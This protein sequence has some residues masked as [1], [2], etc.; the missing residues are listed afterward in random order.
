MPKRV[1]SITIKRRYHPCARFGLFLISN[2][3]LFLSNYVN[4]GWKI[5]DK[6]AKISKD[7]PFVKPHC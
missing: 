6:R 3:Y 1:V 4:Q 2:T 7:Q 5:H